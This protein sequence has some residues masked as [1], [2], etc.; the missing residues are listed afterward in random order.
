MTEQSAEERKIC[1]QCGH[2]N[3]HDA[4][5]CSGCGRP[6]ALHNVQGSAFDEKRSQPIDP[7]TFQPDSLLGADR[8]GEVSVADVTRLVGKKA[9]YYLPVFEQLQHSKKVGRFHF[10]AFVFGGGWMLYRKQ[11]LF[12]ALVLALQ[13]VLQAAA[14][15]FGYLYTL[16]IV[17]GVYAAAG[18]TA[19]QSTITQEQSAA[20]MQ[21]L[22]QISTEQTL[23]SLS[24]VLFWGLGLALAVVI[25]T[26]ANR[27]YFRH[28][29]HTAN[30]VNQQL[31]T[32][33]EEK[34]AEM[35][36][37]GGVNIPLAICLFVCY[38]IVNNYSGAIVSILF[39]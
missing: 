15:I 32:T 30:R 3:P 26:Y 31:F 24:P 21:G 25:G 36:R 16:P 10:S 20:V 17:Q 13:F 34:N 23:L 29:V 19:N 8:F 37:C 39:S 4:V 33:P 28:V 11:Y 2:S 1:P 9:G 18:I 38:F 7:A 5:F 14:L 12:G 27:W 35:V 22:S 6:F